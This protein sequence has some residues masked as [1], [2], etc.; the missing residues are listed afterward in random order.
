MTYWKYLIKVGRR[1]K[2]ER[3]KERKKKIKKY[4][5]SS[6]LRKLKIRETNEGKIK[7]QDVPLT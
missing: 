3:K 5:K 1:R 7:E 2:K 4:F 6:C